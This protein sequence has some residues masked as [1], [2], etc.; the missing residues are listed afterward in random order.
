M[1]LIFE[2]LSKVQYEIYDLKI[3]EMR[4]I[5]KGGW[6]YPTI[7]EMYRKLKQIQNMI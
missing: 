5:E 7:S 1:Q 6:K 2:V 3:Y 4:E